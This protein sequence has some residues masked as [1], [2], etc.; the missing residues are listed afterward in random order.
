MKSKHNGD[1]QVHVTETPDVSHIRNEDVTHEASDVYVR[2]VATVE[3]NSATDNPLV[4]ADSA[5]VI[6]GGN[7]HGQPDEDSGEQNIQ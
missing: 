2:G 5:D 1:G 6:S 3:L 7:F 4:Y